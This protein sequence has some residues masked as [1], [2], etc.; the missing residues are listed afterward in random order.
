MAQ[1][2]LQFGTSRF[3]QAHV[4]LFVSQALAGEGGASAALGG[5]TMV[6]ST[7]SPASTARVAALAGGA[8]YP[9]RLRGLVAGQRV[10]RTV[11]C[12]AVR[13]ALQADA[14][15]PQ[16]REA[17]AQQVQV[18]VSNTAD[19]G[20]QLDA[21]D[22]AALLAPTATAPKSFPA[23][24]LVLL[25][26][27]WQQ[28]PAAPL[29]L[30]PCELVERN[31]DVLRDVVLALAQSWGLPAAYTDW[32]Q[33]QCIW[34]NSLVDRIVS[35]ALQPAGA[36]AEPYALWAVERQPGLVLPCSHPDI[37]LTDDLAHHERLKLL[38]LNAGHTYL[39][40]CW[41]ALQRPA[42]QTVREAMA[43]QEQRA[44]LEALWAEEILPV[45]AALGQTADAEAYLA[46]VRERFENP[47]LN[48]RIADIAQNHAQKK[49]R[50]LGP[51]LALARELGM[52]VP[53]LRLRAASD[54]L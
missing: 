29:T 37:V 39:A 38:L 31:G 34:A 2:I 33:Q 24:L 27:R 22:S 35:E 20:Y 46:T 53:Q 47:F 52:D 17:V 49:Q 5:I 6:Q 7:T 25:H 28:N 10:D 36:V 12:T 3:L 32:L 9:V 4:D 8:G 41:M 13:E 42:E 26:G 44:E 54:L 48:H 18:I 40:E 21:S 43:D 1:P 50:R 45:F 14:H 51:V 16:L 30:L 19:Q 15:W 23:K 11:Q